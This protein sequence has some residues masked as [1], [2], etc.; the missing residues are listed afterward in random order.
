[1]FDLPLNVIF[2]F[3]QMDVILLQLLRNG[4]NPLTISCEFHQSLFGWCYDCRIFF[5]DFRTLEFLPMRHSEFLHILPSEFLLIFFRFINF[6]RLDLQN[7]CRFYM[8]R[9][10]GFFQ[11]LPKEFLRIF[12]VQILCRLDFL[13]FCEFYLHIFLQIYLPVRSS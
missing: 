10:S 11:I 7:F 12:L 8:V 3:L 2:L 6:R 13:N 1:M 5:A 9:P 4:C